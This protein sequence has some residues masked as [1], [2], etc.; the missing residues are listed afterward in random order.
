MSLLLK[1]KG[2][3]LERA[4]DSACFPHLAAVCEGGEGVH[5]VVSRRFHF[6][7]FLIILTI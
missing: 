2:P 7:M 3:A 6:L 4:W 5:I 1:V